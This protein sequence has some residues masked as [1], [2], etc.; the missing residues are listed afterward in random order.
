RRRGLVWLREDGSASPLRGLD[1]SRRMSHTRRAGRE[2]SRGT[3]GVLRPRR[4]AMLTKR[5]GQAVVALL[6]VAVAT[7]PALAGGGVQWTQQFGSP[8]FDA[9]NGVALDGTGAYVVGHTLG[10]LPGEQSSGGPDAFVRKYDLSGNVLWTHQFGTAAFDLGIELAAD[11]TGVYVTG[12]TLGALP[13]QSN[14]GRVD[15]FVR[16]YD[17]DG[18]E[19]W[20]R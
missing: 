10:A 9:A 20:T 14:S 13:G 15:T 4:I 11:G 16:R 1:D 2:P 6:V 19:L 5:V 7:T 17:T 12:W 18:N 3:L 8:A